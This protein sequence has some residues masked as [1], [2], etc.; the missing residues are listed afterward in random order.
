MDSAMEASIGR[1]NPNDLGA[2]QQAR[3]GYKRALVVEKAASMAGPGIAQGDISPAQLASASKAVYGTRAYE[4]GYD[5]FSDLSQ[6]GVAILKQLPDSGTSQ[7]ARINGLIRAG[8][9]GV[10]A[11]LGNHFG[12][13]TEGG[14]LGLLLG[15]SVGE[16]IV[17][18]ALRRTIM[19]RPVQ[20]YLGNQVAA[21][22]PGLLSTAP[23]AL[24]VLRT[25]GQIP[26]LLSPGG[27]Q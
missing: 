4:R 27:A 20:G 23:G 9:A 22:V 14:V 17:R 6:P 19:S 21:G 16:P 1:N 25:A 26:G 2:F 10:G 15:E 7:R 3:G 18:G 5:P 8:G 24:S 11:L 13:A 12:G